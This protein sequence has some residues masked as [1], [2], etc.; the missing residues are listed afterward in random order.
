MFTSCGI[1]KTAKNILTPSIEPTEALTPHKERKIA[2]RAKKSLKRETP[3]LTRKEKKSKKALSKA[4][5]LDPTIVKE[6]IINKIRGL[7]NNP[8]PKRVL[9]IKAPVEV[10]NYT[11]QYRIRVANYRV[12]YDVED[13][14]KTVWIL[15]LRKRGEGTYKNI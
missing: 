4:V 11:A 9:K 12:L 5:E 1:V 15:A 13:K 7:S 10:Y 2:K 8:R 14:K 3:K 6:D